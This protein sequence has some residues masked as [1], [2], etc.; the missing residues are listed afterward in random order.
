MYYFLLILFIYSGISNIQ[1]INSVYD[2]FNFLDEDQ[3][4]RNRIARRSP[5]ELFSTNDENLP[6]GKCEDMEE[7]I[8]LRLSNVELKQIK[9]GFI[10]SPYI[11]CL[12]LDGNMIDDLVPGAFDNLPNLIYLDLSRNQIP[13]NSLMPVDT[14]ENLTTLILDENIPSPYSGLNPGGLL[15]VTGYFPKLKY[16]YLRKNGITKISPNFTQNVPNLS[17]LY[18]SENAIG[19]NILDFAHN[20][21]NSLTHVYLERNGIERI[22]GWQLMYLVSLF[23]DGNNIRTLCYEI[24]D[25]SSLSL[26]FASNLE[27]LSISH[28]N[29][30]TIN[31]T[32]F[33]DT[34]NLLSLDL[35]HNAIETIG[36]GTFNET[37]RLANLS[38]DHNLLTSIPDLSTMYNIT[39]LYLNDNYIQNIT[40]GTFSNLSYLTNVTLNNNLIEYVEPLA[41]SNLPMLMELDLSNNKI[42]H[43][44]LNWMLAQMNLRNLYL[45]MNKFESLDEIAVTDII[46][47]V[48]L[49]MND[50]LLKY[51]TK[52]SFEYLPENTTLYIQ[53]KCKVPVCVWKDEECNIRCRH[54]YDPYYYNLLTAMFRLPIV[55]CM[56]VALSESHANNSLHEIL[57]L[58]DEDPVIRNHIFRRSPEELFSRINVSL[59]FGRCQDANANM[60]LRLSNSGLRN[61]NPGFIQSPQIE[62]LSLDDNMIQNVMPNAFDKLPNL[63]YLDLSRNQIPTNVLIPVDTFNNL[64]TLVLDENIDFLGISRDRS[65]G[66]LGYFPKLKYLYLRKNG[67]V[68]I[69]PSF[70][71]NLPNLTHLFLS[72]NEIGNGVLHF[73]NNVSNSLTH[74]YLERNGIQHVTVWQLLYIEAIFLDGNNIKMLCNKY[75]SE[76]SLSLKFAWSLETLSM[77]H[78]DLEIIEPDTFD[79]AVNLLNLDLSYNAIADIRE[80]TFSKISRLSNLSLNHNLLTTIPD[81]SRLYNLTYLYLNSNLIRKIAKD[82]FSYM[83]YLTNVKLNDNLIEYIEPLAFSKLP[84]LMELDISNN[85]LHRL[86]LNWM[87][88]QKNL[89]NL[90]L[91]FNQFESLDDVSLIGVKS[92]KGLYMNKNPLKFLTIRSLT[93]LPLNTTLYVESDCEASK[94]ACEF[95]EDD[96]DKYCPYLR[97]DDYDLDNSKHFD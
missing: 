56:F 77:S 28:N 62:C 83:S 50:N 90:Y 85:S 39:N 75:C 19:D 78:N 21:P 89:R 61:I 42:H 96:C 54:L 47:L 14:F 51:I 22:V 7:N 63:I 95:G 10:D 46:S 9:A 92:L 69:L 36:E 57:H 31:P 23:L 53:R 20:I 74:V 80:E 88:P 3:T 73:F 72:D 49:H 33:V 48:G 27:T 87:L 6:I 2:I 5:N 32:A 97:N 17:Y 70:A 18:L 86:A 84:M 55:L 71:Q 8:P 64:T 52:K 81:L 67:I 91:N 43:L 34:D 1:G 37:V 16:L 40:R 82:T 35:S 65:L 13:T 25:Q 12:S 76:S 11:S 59:P 93:D 4:T 24:C 79:N 29:L 44:P 41:F 66:A 26:K 30:K 58:P 38:L 45:N 68:E 94:C 15:R 60:S